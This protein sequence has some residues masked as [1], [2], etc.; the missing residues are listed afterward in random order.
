MGDQLTAL[1][2]I[3]TEFYY[4]VTVVIMFL[5]HVG[6]CMYE[7]GVSRRRNHLHTLM[8]NTMLIPLVTITFFFFESRSAVAPLAS[9]RKGNYRTKRLRDFGDLA[10]YQEPIAAILLHRLNAAE[11]I[12]QSALVVNGER[13]RLPVES[14]ADGLGDNQQL[15][16]KI[17]LRAHAGILA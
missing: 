17:G 14:A 6:F 12:A 3:F 4:W 7:V 1:T 13:H 5:I 8:K 11:R 16:L 2:T 10:D 9:D 15:L